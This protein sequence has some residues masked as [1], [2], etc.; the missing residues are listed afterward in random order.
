[1]DLFFFLVS[2][3]VKMK[4]RLQTESSSDWVAAL[5]HIFVIRDACCWRAASQVY[6][7]SCVLCVWHGRRAH[8]TASLAHLWFTFLDEMF[9]RALSSPPA[10]SSPVLPRIRPHF[11]SRALCN[12]CSFVYFC[13]CMGL[14]LERPRSQ[15]TKRERVKRKVGFAIGSSCCSLRHLWGNGELDTHSSNLPLT[16]PYWRQERRNMQLCLMWLCCDTSVFF[17]NGCDRGLW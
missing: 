9:P 10:P 1:M 4:V 3:T 16:R 8:F 13:M 6:R 14:I 2:K 5:C 11:K 17:L 7:G 12:R 15:G